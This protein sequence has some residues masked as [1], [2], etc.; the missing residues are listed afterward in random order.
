MVKTKQDLTSKIN[1]IFPN[2]DK[3]LESEE[4]RYSGEEIARI[5]AII[6]VRK[7]QTPDDFKRAEILYKDEFGGGSEMVYIIGHGTIFYQFHPGSEHD[8]FFLKKWYK[9]QSSRVASVEHKAISHV[10]SF[11]PVYKPFIWLE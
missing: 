4:Y 10:E 9:D 1:F 2:L 11:I 6:S 3:K 8:I 7:S 5:N